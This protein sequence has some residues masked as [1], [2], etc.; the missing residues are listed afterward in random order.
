MHF[1]FI[2][3]SEPF[4]LFLVKHPFKCRRTTGALIFLTK[5][6]AGAAF[7]IFIRLVCSVSKVWGHDR[8][9]VRTRLF[10]VSSLWLTRIVWEFEWVDQ[11]PQKKKTHEEVRLV[12]FK[13]NAVLQYYG[14]NVLCWRLTHPYP[15][16]C[17]HV[18]FSILHSNPK[19]QY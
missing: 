11:K 16:L 13:H 12:F 9:S 2:F 10:F 15:L 3:V 14:I 4:T 18:I 5:K 6:Y 17:D 7:F 8:K 1:I 19:I